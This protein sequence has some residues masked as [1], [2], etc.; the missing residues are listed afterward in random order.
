MPAEFDEFDE[1]YASHIITLAALGYLFEI[2][3]EVYAGVEVDDELTMQLL[4][5]DRP[6]ITAVDVARYC[7]RHGYASGDCPETGEGLLQEAVTNRRVEVKFRLREILGD[8]RLF[9]SLVVAGPPLPLP[10]F[11][12]EGEEIEAEPL[13]DPLAEDAF[14]RHFADVTSDFS[15]AQA[16]EWLCDRV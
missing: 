10:E 3:R 16:Y 13:G 8:S 6:D 9:T 5:T 11:D 2:F 14:D 15:G 4:G 1:E 12:D 7:E